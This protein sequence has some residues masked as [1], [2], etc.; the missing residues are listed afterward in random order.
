MV[1][2]ITAMTYAVLVPV[3][4]GAF[5]DAAMEFFRRMVRQA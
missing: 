4:I 5:A 2:I 1:G 3:L